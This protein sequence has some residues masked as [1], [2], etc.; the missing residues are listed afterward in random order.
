MSITTAVILAA[1][2]YWFYCMAMGIRG[3]LRARSASGYFIAGRTLPIWLFLLA[4]SATSFSGWT[5]IG[6]SGLVFGNG[7]A[8]AYAGMYAITIPFTGMLFLK[9]QWIL[10]RRYGFVTPTEMY[11]WYFDSRV[12]FICIALIV[13]FY[14]TFY[15]AVQLISSGILFTV[16]TGGK[17]PYFLGS[18]LLAFIMF[19]YVAAGG[20]RPVAWVDALQFFL[21]VFGMSILAT[22]ILFGM[23]GW[24]VFMEKVRLL[25]YYF[26][27]NHGFWRLDWNWIGPYEQYIPLTGETTIITMPLWTG[28]MQFT[29][30]FA[31]AGIQCSPAFTSWAFSQ[32]NPHYIPW[33]VINIGIVIGLILCFYPMIAGMGGRILGMIEGNPTYTP[34]GLRAVVLGAGAGGGPTDALIPCLMIDY[35]PVVLIAFV[36]IGGLAAMQSTGAPYITN[37]TAVY[38]RDVLQP[39]WFRIF[40][41]KPAFADG[42][43]AAKVVTRE[44][45]HQTQMWIGRLMALIV[46]VLAFIVTYYQQDMI[47]M[48]G[49][50][51]VSYAWCLSIAL[52]KICYNFPKYISG[53]ALAWG[54]FG[55]IVAVTATYWWVDFRYPLTIHS[56][57][58]G[59]ITV[60]VVSS[61]L[62]LFLKKSKLE[63]ERA[64][65]VHSYF[66]VVDPVDDNLRKWR[67]WT[68]AVGFPFWWVTAFIVPQVF[69]KGFVWGIPWQWAYVFL[70]VWPTGVIML[71]LGAFKCQFSFWKYKRKAEVVEP[72]TAKAADTITER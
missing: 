3:Y 20:L 33:M 36:A 67:F 59:I 52:C 17:I 15:V 46:L 11:R 65:E 21:M 8:Y 6:H 56:A 1:V 28:L 38:T 45:S 66:Q 2:L 68:A 4:A 34:A 62:S 39:I 25:P 51:A 13:I 55:G 70:W 41:P 18:I 26:T 32:K 10:G 61:I 35:L 47:V 50:L 16:L 53:Q 22:G 44:W 14:S 27:Q 31:L 9:R 63:I 19:F 37:F 69:V 54:T 57:G 40:K 43:G 58:W 12:W 24:G 60:L 42:G 5:Y 29:Y 71:Y 23:G 48:L 72:I 49:G 30:M 7:L 64:K